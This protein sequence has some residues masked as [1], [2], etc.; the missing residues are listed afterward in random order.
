MCTIELVGMLCSRGF[1]P[2]SNF[3]TI[4]LHYFTTLGGGVGGGGV[5][6]QYKSVGVWGGRWGSRAGRWR[7]DCSLCGQ[8]DRS[9][10]AIHAHACRA[11]AMTRA[12]SEVKGGVRRRL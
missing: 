4:T 8:P 6:V 11:V 1:S 12:H 3:G 5:G 2:S 9:A 10:W 7:S